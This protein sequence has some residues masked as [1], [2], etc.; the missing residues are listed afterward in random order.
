M[1]QVWII[2]SLLL[3][4]STGFIGERYG[5]N[6]IKV[7]CDKHDAAQQQV[8][9]AAENNVIAK[10]KQSE[11][12]TVQTAQSYEKTVDRI[13]VDDDDGV[14]PSGTPASGSMSAIPIPAARTCPAAV[15]ASKTY[16]LTL[17]QC[18]I[19]EAKLQHLWAWYAEQSK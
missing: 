14:Q 4:A 9:I 12:T 10:Q 5:E 13:N 11:A 6:R 16:K 8:T 18:D 7:Q 3:L 2:F 17:K 19:E 1:N 15:T